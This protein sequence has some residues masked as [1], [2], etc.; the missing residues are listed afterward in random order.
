MEETILVTGATGNVGSQ[1]VRQ[2]SSF[3]VKVRAAVQ[4]KLRAGE[5]KNTSAELVEMNFNRS[6]TIGA[7]FKDIQK[8]F[9]LTPFVPDMVDMSKNL[10][11][12]AKEA[13]V[14][15]IVKQSAFGSHLEDGITMN[16]LHRQVEKIIESSGI[17]YTFLRPMSFMQ[18]YLGLSDSIKTRSVFYQPLG[19]SKTSFV[20]TRDIAAVAV[21]ALTK[22]REHEN[23]AYNV[24]GPE[25]VSNYEIANILSEILGRKVTYIDISDDDARKAMKENGMQEWTINSLMELSNFQKAGKA[26]V[27]S[28]D[29][30]QVTGRKPIT[31]NQFAKDHIETFR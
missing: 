19:D 3:G 6:E 15:H 8:L 9:L 11:G 2:L 23:K 20:D 21:G 25:A 14:D 7:A 13:N 4:S 30:E 27:I 5:I 31:F 24:T 16:K 28:K 29:A 18:N 10:V 12:Q 26:S 22:S 1:V 17:S